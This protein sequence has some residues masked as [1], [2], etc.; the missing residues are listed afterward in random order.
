M[1][2]LIR[3]AWEASQ[4]QLSSTR[5]GQAQKTRAQCLLTS[6]NQ[7]MAPELMVGNNKVGCDSC[8]GLR[9]KRLSQASKGEKTG[10]VYSNASKQL[11]IYSP[12]PVLTLHMKRFEVHSSSPR[13]I[14]RHTQFGELLDLAPFCSAISQDLPHMRRG[15]RSVL[16]SLFG[17]VEHSSAA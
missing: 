15:Q 3:F 8:T 1:L 7:C 16:Y 4:I 5:A 6:L 10:T 2:F 12:P 11:P 13:K 14:N 9:N 17:L